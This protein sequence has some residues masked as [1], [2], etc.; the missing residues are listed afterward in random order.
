MEAIVKQD[1]VY[2]VVRS[3]EVVREEIKSEDLEK[4][5]TIVVGDFRSYKEVSSK[6]L[7][8]G[9]VLIQRGN[10]VCL[11]TIDGTEIC[12]IVCYE[13]PN[14]IYKTYRV[15]RCLFFEVVAAYLNQIEHLGVD[16][17]LSNY[18]A[19]LQALKNEVADLL[20][21]LELEQTVNY[22][23]TKVSILNNLRVFL[24]DLSLLAFTLFSSMNA[25]LE[26]QVYI[27]AYDAA[28]SHISQYFNV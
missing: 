7:Y 2:V 26:N 19:Q 20:E 23:K 4:D 22:D 28:V 10:N 9:R 21:K 17:F 13:N 12:R 14:T 15:D 24:Q 27:N 11:L 8:G 6:I 25:G 3:K 1:N 16:A 5:E 18:K